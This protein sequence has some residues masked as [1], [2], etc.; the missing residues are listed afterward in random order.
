MSRSAVGAAVE[1]AIE[2]AALVGIGEKEMGVFGCIVESVGEGR[3]ESERVGGVGEGAGEVVEL[4][5]A[6]VV[7]FII[8]DVDCIIGG[9]VGILVGIVG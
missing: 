4:V 5:G 2:G 6:S 8:G 7:V 9:D 1:V 3:G